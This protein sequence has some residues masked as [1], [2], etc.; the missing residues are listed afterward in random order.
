MEILLSRANKETIRLVGRWRIDI[1]LCYIHMSPQT[2]ISGLEM[3]MVQH[4]KYAIILPAH[5]G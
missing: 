1:I 5:G 2:F 3:R 4:R